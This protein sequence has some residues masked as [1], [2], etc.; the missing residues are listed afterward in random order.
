MSVS[1]D[2]YG[3]S[4]AAMDEL[5]EQQ[6][7]D[8][9]LYMVWVGLRTWRQCCTLIAPIVQHL[10]AHDSL[11]MEVGLLY[12]LYV[13]PDGLLQFL[14]VI[15]PRGLWTQFLDAVHAGL[16]NRHPDIEKTQLKLRYSSSRLQIGVC[17]LLLLEYYYRFSQPR[18]H[19][20]W[21]LVLGYYF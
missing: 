9:E 21:W 17:N 5:K 12:W 15:V 8:T 13:R 16:M 4:V 1:Q 3:S 10:W 11:E 7:T 20:Q 14:Q 6:T 18:D 2:T 19:L